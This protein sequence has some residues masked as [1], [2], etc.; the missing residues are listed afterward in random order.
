MID[1]SKF[2]NERIEFMDSL[3]IEKFLS[4]GQAFVPVNIKNKGDSVHLYYQD[5]TTE[6]LDMKSTLFLSKLLHYFDCI[7]LVL[8]FQ[9]I[10]T[11]MEN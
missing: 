11:D 5:G 6:V 10:V 8:A 1:K 4:S 2:R 7:I 9:L 3:L